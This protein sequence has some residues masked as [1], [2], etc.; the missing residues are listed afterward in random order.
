MRDG[1]AHG[2]ARAV[3]RGAAG[4]H[5][6]QPL[7]LLV[8]GPPGSGKSVV[9]DA[10]GARTGIVT[11]H[12]DGFKEPLMTDLG[13]RSAAESSALSAA[14]VRMLFVSADAL[15]RRGIDVIIESTL[16]PDD[17]ARVRALQLERQCAVIQ[18]HVTATIGVLVDRWHARMGRRHPGHLDSERLPEMR[19]RAEAG[20]WDALQLDA[21]LL[22]IDTSDADDFDVDQ[23]LDELRRA[24]AAAATR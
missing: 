14:A 4:A 16:N 5:T 9:A 21:P 6:H 7:L 18:L 10:L 22:R 20:T 12:K 11:L 23:W 19:A 1:R 15:L 24:Q 2:A 3:L 17:V 8:G 13:V